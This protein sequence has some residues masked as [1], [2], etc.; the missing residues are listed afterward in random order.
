MYTVDDY[1]KAK[2]ALK[3]LNDRFDRYDGNNPNKYQ[4]DLK[5]ARS[6]LRT[7]EAY[8]KEV[9]II[10]ITD[11]ERIEKVLNKAF[12]NAKSKE[13]VE[14]EGKCYQLRFFPLEMSRSR[15]TVTEWGK[16][17]VEVR[18]PE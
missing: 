2:A 1:E 5:M 17:W 3:K 4:A 11:K 16:S 18:E 8:L 14:F 7:I 13:V 15:K 9:G 10:A 12:P 6:R